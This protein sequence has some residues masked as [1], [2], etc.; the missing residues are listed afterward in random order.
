MSSSTT[1]SPTRE[2][3]VHCTHKLQ[4]D[5]QL[6]ADLWQSDKEIC[7]LLNHYYKLG[8]DRG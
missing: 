5:M 7:R 8:V 6:L 1:P 4:Q 3:I 2:E